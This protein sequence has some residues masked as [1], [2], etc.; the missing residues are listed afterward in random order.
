MIK[1]AKCPKCGRKLR[2]FD[3]SQYCPECG[4]NMRFYNFEE[5]FYRE[6]KEVE[7]SQAKFHVKMRRVKTALVGSKL[8]IARLAL[9]LLPIITFLI[10]AGNFTV[11]LPFKT[12]EISVGLIGV[13][14]LVM[15]SD[16]GYLFSVGNSALIGAEFSAI[17]KALVSYAV[18]LIFALGVLISTL[19]CFVS[20]KKMQKTICSFAA[21]G[22]GAAIAAQVLMYV[23]VSQLENA[24]FTTGSAGFGLY[25]TLVGFLVVFAVNRKIDKDGI[26]VEYDEGMEERVAIY[27]KVKAGEI[28]ID[29]L[30]QPIIETEETRKIEEEI[31]KEEEKLQRIL[32]EREEAE[33]K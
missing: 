3:I 10:P 28:N 22:I 25:I 29:D 9:C 4:V 15:G 11:I 2:L 6:A 23:T 27:E 17:T 5:N 18:V 12:T 30:P 13:I 20:I 33:N 1:M 31:L 21:A 16:L 19:L 7:L 24:I 26:K 14:N 32:A 8:I